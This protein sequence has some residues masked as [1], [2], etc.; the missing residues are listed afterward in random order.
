MLEAICTLIGDG[1]GIV[2]TAERRKLIDLF[3]GSRDSSNKASGVRALFD[4]STKDS[5]AF[6]EA[7]KGLLSE[8]DFTGAAFAPTKAIADE[9]R[10]NLEHL[11][12]RLALGDPTALVKEQQ[13]EI[14][15]KE[16]KA[17]VNRAQMAK[18]AHEKQEQR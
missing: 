5:K 3:P 6:I 16:Y 7:L 2:T 1:D 4:N 11:I 10:Q 18:I 14:L 12:R 13:Q 17:L 9:H 8:F 15:D